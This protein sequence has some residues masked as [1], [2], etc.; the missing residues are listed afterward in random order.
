[1]VEAL[2]S[3]QFEIETRAPLEIN[4][5]GEICSTTPALLRV[6]PGMLDVFAPEE[7]A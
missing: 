3:T 7:P 2:R 1:M 6:H 4:V 5:D